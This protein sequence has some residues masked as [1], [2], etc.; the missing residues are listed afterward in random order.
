M[1]RQEKPQQKKNYTYPAQDNAVCVGDEVSPLEGKARRG[2]QFDQHT[3]GDTRGRDR[4]RARNARDSAKVLGVRVD[5]S[6]EVLAGDGEC[7]WCDNR[8]AE[9]NHHGGSYI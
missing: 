8:R 3:V 6:T 2:A 7:C 5:D 9:D 1:H 4:D